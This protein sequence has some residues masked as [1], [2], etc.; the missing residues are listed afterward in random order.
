MGGFTESAWSY[1]RKIVL[2]LYITVGSLRHNFVLSNKGE[3]VEIATVGEVYY[4]FKDKQDKQYLAD[5]VEK[6]SVA[7]D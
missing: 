6:Y 2:P 3:I 5:F 4:K 1:S 7:G